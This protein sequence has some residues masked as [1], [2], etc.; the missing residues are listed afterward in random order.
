M[1]SASPLSDN[2]GRRSA[3]LKTLTRDVHEKLDNAIMARAP[4]DSLDGYRRFL[5]MQYRFHRDIDALYDDDGLRS[6]LP[7]LAARRRLPAIVAD[8]DDLGIAAPALDTPPVFTPD[9]V[10]VPA[11]LGWLYVA[12]GSNLGAAILRRMASGLGLSDDH[13][14][15]HLAPAV[16]GPAA[17]WRAFTEALDA[18]GL[19]PEDDARAAREAQAAF[20]RVWR[21]T[22]AAFAA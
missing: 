15:R 7:D 12:E 14:A 10:A 5:D 11:A 8:L 17:Q 20:D 21:Y 22:E 9:T 13:G 3:R 6:L 2:A 19:T 4:F 16:E 18:I 1:T